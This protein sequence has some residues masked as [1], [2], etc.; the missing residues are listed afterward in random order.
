[1]YPGA[2]EVGLTLM[3]RVVNQMNNNS[4]R[5]FVR[6]ASERAPFII[7][8]YEDRSLGETIKYHLL[9]AGC[10]FASS[11]SE[12]DLVLAVN[13]P[14]DDMEEA[15]SHPSKS[16]SYCVE[17]NITE[18]VFFVEDC[19]KMG[20]PVVIGDNAYANGADLELIALLDKRKLLDK[21][22]GYAGRRM[23]EVGLD[24][25]YIR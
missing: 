6:Y 15:A 23:F 3:A 22:A 19:I 8:S 5:V 9:A 16:Q 14:A 7:P 1:M 13:C 11:I 2:D 10:R 17:R 4:P 18:F 25:S 21:V 12:A 24:V 20:K